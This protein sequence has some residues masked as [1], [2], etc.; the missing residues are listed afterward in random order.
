VTT[1]IQVTESCTH[2]GEGPFWDPRVG[3]LCL[4]DMLAG[5]VVEWDTRG[6]VVR[7]PVGT[8]AAVVR[9]RAQG[10]Y[11]LGVE[12]GFALASDDFSVVETL[13]EVFAGDTIRMNDGG[14]DPQGRFYCG[15]MAYAMTPGAGTL[16]R[17]NADHSV[18]RVLTGVTISNGLQ[19]SRD[20]TTVYYSDTGTGRV[21]AFDF[22]PG[23]GDFSRR[24]RFVAIES[25]VGAPDGLAIDAEDGVWVALW[26]GGAVHR[27][28]ARGRLSEV[29]DL[30]VPKVTACAFGG[31]DGQTLYITTS[32][33][34]LASGEQPE[35]G[36][37]FSTRTG[38]TGAPQHAFV[39]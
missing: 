10:G 7:H 17:L 5:V 4:V 14:C 36:A 9:A 37:I 2:H 3:R 26:G 8:V 32:R 11:V 19:W 27:Y 22:D 29:V 31:D 20:G 12:R 18:E 1:A 34:G 6:P 28:D 16:Y 24:R 38:V 30:P 35:A 13:P 39:G 33:D 15:S 25:G 23:T 21:D